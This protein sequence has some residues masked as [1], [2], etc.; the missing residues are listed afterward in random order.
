M[1][2]EWT[3][4]PATHGHLIVIHIYKTSYQVSGLCRALSF[5]KWDLSKQWG[6]RNVCKAKVE[7]AINNADEYFG[8]YHS[9]SF[10][11]EN[12][13]INIECGRRKL[14]LNHLWGINNQAL[15]ETMGNMAIDF[16][17][18]EN[19]V[20]DFFYKPKISVRWERSLTLFSLEGQMKY[21]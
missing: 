3:C 17:F 16:S 21:L 7:L 18:R 14:P 11:W 19:V 1:C 8:A 4:F 5:I 9:C 20:D 12:T 2:K 6:M 15:I 13:N 10:D